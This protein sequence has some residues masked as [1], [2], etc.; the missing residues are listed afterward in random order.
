VQAQET[1]IASALFNAS[2][3]IGVA[4]GLAVLSTISVAVT[5]GKLP[6]ALTALYRARE[7]GNTEIVR[8]ASDA[9]VHG[10]GL[11]LAGSG[12]A[13]VIAA[14]IAAVLVNAKREQVSTQSA[15]LH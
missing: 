10:Y 8:S 3:Q 14:I 9:L 2:Q 12:V 13:L 15:A 7:A 11:A 6:H 1:G 5:A 4:F